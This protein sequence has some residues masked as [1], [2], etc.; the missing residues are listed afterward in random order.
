VNIEN[1]ALGAHTVVE[2]LN[3]DSVRLLTR[4]PMSTSNLD[5]DEGDEVE[6]LPTAY[7]NSQSPGKK[8]SLANA[9]KSLSPKLASQNSRLFRSRSNSE[10][11]KG[12]MKKN[13]QSKV[14][15]QPMSW[16]GRLTNATTRQDQSSPFA[17]QEMFNCCPRFASGNIFTASCLGV[18][19]ARAYYTPGIIELVEAIL[20][21]DKKRQESFPYQI[22]IPSSCAGKPYSRIIDKLL[23]GWP[24]QSSSSD[25]CQTPGAEFNEV[26][27][28]AMPLGI[29]RTHT[30]H[31][32]HSNGF[33]D[34]AVSHVIT[35]P[36]RTFILELT[37]LVFVIGSVAFGA[38]CLNEGIL[39][40]AAPNNPRNSNGA[41]D[42]LM[43]QPA[44][45]FNADAFGTEAFGP[46]FGTEISDASL[47]LQSQ[48]D[49]IKPY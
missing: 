43:S 25:D 29:Y 12:L 49:P 2:L 15:A 47:Q 3:E 14:P 28:G 27:A 33:E 35:N 40:E 8:N 30:P 19:M 44:S 45:A 4:Y 22:R 18:L 38:A 5:D 9:R 37:D 20:L 23:S 11:G 34:E 6:T 16:E 21:G 42:E 31:G 48:F 1:E 41:G 32:P 7:R 17:D 10:I 26:A 36:P 39:V 46:A 24:M 13:R